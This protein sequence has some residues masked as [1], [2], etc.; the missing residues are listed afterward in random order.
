[1]RLLVPRTAGLRRF[2]IQIVWGAEDAVIPATHAKALP[3]AKV[4]I[5]DGVGHMAM[6]EAAGRV[7][8]LIRAQ[9]S[10]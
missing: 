3:K 5:I 4:E 2:P 7:N 9:V 6:M 1:M 8:E 10:N